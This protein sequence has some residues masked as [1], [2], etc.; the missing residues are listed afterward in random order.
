MDG[1]WTKPTSSVAA[2]LQAA[3]TLLRETTA[4]SVRQQTSAVE[5]L[6]VLVRLANGG[7]S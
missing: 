7:K 1:R 4:A 6:A 3:A 5:R 2:K